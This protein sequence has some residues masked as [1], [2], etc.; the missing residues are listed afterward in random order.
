MIQ[1]SLHN[2]IFTG[3]LWNLEYPKIYFSPYP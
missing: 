3:D 1:F 2:F